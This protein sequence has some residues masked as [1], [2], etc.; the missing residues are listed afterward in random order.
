[1]ANDLL[2]TQ[3]AENIQAAQFFLL[4]FLKFVEGN[5]Q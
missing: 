4:A 2:Y 3:G 1:M 5:K